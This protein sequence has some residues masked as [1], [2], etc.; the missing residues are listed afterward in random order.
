MSTG[1]LAAELGYDPRW[2]DYGILSAEELE[3]QVE[4]FRRSS[5]KHTEHYRWRAFVEFFKRTDTLSDDRIERFLRINTTSADDILREPQLHAL[6]RFQGLTDTQIRS[7]ARHSLF[8]EPGLARVARRHRLLRHLDAP[9]LHRRIVEAC[10]AAND[11]QVHSALVEHEGVPLWALRELTD[12]GA[13]KSVR[14]R[15]RVSSR[16]IERRAG[17]S[18]SDVEST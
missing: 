18:R 5:D 14:N 3:A 17:R 12:R 2:I 13:N 4:L 9:K 8:E 1:D 16:S 7:L 6:I 15:A 11:S 10:L